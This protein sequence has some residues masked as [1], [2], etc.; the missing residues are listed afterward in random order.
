MPQFIKI[1][2]ILPNLCYIVLRKNINS[3]VCIAKKKKRVLSHLKNCAQPVKSGENPELA[4]LH[5]WI[6]PIKLTN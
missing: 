1:F 2:K 4:K 6:L 3:F 5:Y